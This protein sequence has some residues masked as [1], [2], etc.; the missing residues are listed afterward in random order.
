[1]SHSPGRPVKPDGQ[2]RKQ[3]HISL[4]SEDIDHLDQLT[5]NRSDF[6]RHCI[7]ESW[8]KQEEEDVTVSLTLPKWVVREMLHFVEETLTP[9]ETTVV[10]KLMKRLMSVN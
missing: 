7:T 4:Y 8:Q 2:K 5:D 6:L 10:Q 1:M 9:E 3:L